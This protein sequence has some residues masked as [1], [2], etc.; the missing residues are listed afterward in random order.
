MLKGAQVS[1]KELVL[2]LQLGGVQSC[3]TTTV[4]VRDPS[5]NWQSLCARAGRMPPPQARRG[6]RASVTDLASNTTDADFHVVE[7]NKSGAIIR[8]FT[9]PEHCAKILGGPNDLVTQREIKAA[10]NAE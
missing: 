1:S 7:V 2:V 4:I 3:R 6:R 5:L 9:H 8:H 10:C